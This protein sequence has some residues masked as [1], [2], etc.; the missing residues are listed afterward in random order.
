[1]RG[2]HVLHWEQRRDTLPVAVGIGG[3]P[4]KGDVLKES[5]G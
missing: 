3:L 1:M 2:T 4:E 5:W